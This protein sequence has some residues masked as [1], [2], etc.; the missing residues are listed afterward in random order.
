MDSIMGTANTGPQD[1]ARCGGGGGRGRA[2]AGGLGRRWRRVAGLALGPSSSALLACCATRQARRLRPPHFGHLPRAQAAAR[3]PR[4]C[5]QGGSRPPGGRGPA[6]SLAR[7][8]CPRS[9]ITRINRVLQDLL[10]TNP[11][12]VGPGAA[13]AAGAGAEQQLA[14][15]PGKAGVC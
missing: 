10:A 15:A 6:D 5:W 13:G 9:T 4:C 2:G 8:P 7:G 14:Q 12:K 3:C 1:N 11:L